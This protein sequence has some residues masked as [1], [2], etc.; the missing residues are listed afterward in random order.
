MSDNFDYIIVGAGSAGC[1]LA[2]RLSRDPEVKVLLLEG[3]PL[4]NSMYISMPKGLGKLYETS[5]YCYFYQVHRG[6]DDTGS[7]EVWLRG[8]G[9]GGSS[10]INGLMYQRGHPDDYNAWEDDLGLTGW[11]WK[12]LGPIFKSMED[13]ELG[14]NDHRGAGG[15][16]AVSLNAN[17]TSLMDKM[18]EA[19]A[20][21]G[22]P[23]NSDANTPD[24][25]GIGYVNTTIRDGRR[26]S[27]AR[28]F[29]DAARNRK[30]LTIVTDIAVDRILFVD[31]RAVGV[32]CRTAGSTVQFHARQEI[33][34]ATGA[35]ESPKLLQLSG[36]GPEQLLTKFGIPVIQNS[37]EVGENLREHLVFRIQ[38]RLK[39]D[40]GQNRDHT[41]WR[42]LLHT[43]H[44]A[45]TKKG[46]MAAPPYD[47]TGFVRVRE[48]A[49]RPDAQIFIGGVS[50]DLT[51]AQE[52]YSVKLAMEKE[53]GA[54]I[55]GYG[56][57]PRS[58]GHVRIAS[59][60][61]EV[62]LSIHANYLTDPVDREVAVGIVRYMR[63]LFDQPAARDV[64][65]G[66]TFPGAGI[67]TDEQIL[68][69]YRAMGG[70]GYHAAGTCR[71]GSD[72][73]SVV[74]ERLRVRGVTGLRVADISVFPTMVS[75]NTNAPAM[76]AGWRAADL[77]AEDA[78]ANMLPAV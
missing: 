78:R 67:A 70:P 19:G 53:P 7:P 4:D 75:G 18:I 76:A 49:T 31:R 2:N 1:V 73:D 23:V 30:N 8:R 66:E 44:Y 60:D 52:Q 42:L 5:K 63:A 69:A 24:Q 35:I 48:A 25:E 14:A 77:I 29:L 34:L 65:A 59:A 26:W 37:P 13:H 33:V 15:P 10:S 51:A 20:Q 55:I 11:G 6:A 61:P 12:T 16:V 58:K 27:A 46:I 40:I 45:L 17:R 57:R 36:I 47:V 39:N 72:A 21:L 56:L 71:M 54:S 64:I 38:Y 22:L 41:G 50:M 9:I 74:D 32:A 43:T 3:G 62:P 28:A 68:E